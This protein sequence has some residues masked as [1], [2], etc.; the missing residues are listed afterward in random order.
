MSLT[1]IPLYAESWNVAF[2][3]RSQGTILED[4]STPFTVIPNSFRYWAADPMVFSHQGQTY[5]FAELFDYVLR[6]GVIGVTRYLGDGSFGPWEP[7]LREEFHMSYPYVFRSGAEIFM[8][9]ET[10]R[11]D[12]LLLYRAVEFPMCWELHKVIRENVKWADTS[13][14]PDGDGFSGYT[15]AYADGRSQDL[16]LRLNGALELVGETPLPGNDP[17]IYRPGGRPFAHGGRV[18]RIC[19]DCRE[20]YGRALYF[21]PEDCPDGD[22]RRITPEELT[23]SKTMP[24]QGM[25]TYTATEEFEVIDL[26]TRRLNPLNLLF[27]IIGKFSR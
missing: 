14:T 25:H 16:H 1:D 11:R 19:Q 27:R 5:I 23:L 8:I 24:L 7:I 17:R 21:R 20:G 18:Y 4:H 6:R 2:R 3:L 12:A 10:T 26:K 15:Q 13:I 9:P 22:A